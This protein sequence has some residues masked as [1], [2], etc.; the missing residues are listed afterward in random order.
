MKN[1][2]KT[3]NKLKQKRKCPFNDFP[4]SSAEDES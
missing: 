2:N 3:T 1:K 4:P